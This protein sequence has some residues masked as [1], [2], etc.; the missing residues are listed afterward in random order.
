MT[1]D[2]A[3]FA[4]L[5]Q[6]HYRRLYA[7]CRRRTDAQSAEDAV[8]ETFLVAWRRVAE[9]PSDD[10]ML[11]W[12]Y[13]V[14]YRVLGHQ[15]RGLSRRRRLD[16]KLSAIGVTSVAPAEDH[17]VIRAE[18]STVRQAASRLKQSD[19]E[20]LRLA[21]WE[22]LPQDDIA[23]ALDLTIDAV[24]QRLSRAKRK[25]ATEY[26]RLEKRETSAPAAQ[27]GGGQ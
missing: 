18:Q 24:R 10:K 25:L 2:D 27:K 4:D 14:A 19:V 3:Q 11:P 23:V 8:A 17:V 5:Y 16:K 6:R 21:L 12:L 9:L 20:I 26:H 7:Y 1:T 22:E 13:G 15:F